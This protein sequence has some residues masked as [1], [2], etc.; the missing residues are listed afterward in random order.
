MT[1][2]LSQWRR[3]PTKKQPPYRP[4]LEA[5]EQRWLPTSVA[6][7]AASYG[8]SEYS[9]SFFV[10]VS[11]D[12]APSGT[13]T[14][15]YATADGTA[16]AGSDYTATSGTLTFTPS[17]T[18]A[19]VAI[20]IT[21][22]SE[23]E[24]NETFTFTLSSPGAGLTLGSP[25]SATITIQDTDPRHP[26][27]AA[28]PLAVA[29]DAGLAT[30]TVN[31][32]GAMAV[33]AT[34]AYATRDG[35]AVSAGDLYYRDYLPVT[36][37]LTFVPGQS[38]AWFT[39]PIVD[40]MI[41]GE[42][43]EY[44]Y[45]D[46]SNPSSG[47]AWP[48]SPTATLTIHDVTATDYL[49]TAPPSAGDPDDRTPVA[50]GPVTVDPQDGDVS[51]GHDLSGDGGGVVSPGGS[52]QDA[53]GCGCPAV[54]WWNQAPGVATPPDPSAERGG[55]LLD[56]AGRIAFR[57]VLR[58][59]SDTAQPRPV[60]TTT[61]AT[62]AA[63]PAPAA[64]SVRLVRGGVAQAW[65]TP[66]PAGLAAGDAF[67]VGQQADAAVAAT[68]YYEYT[69]QVM[70]GYA[71]RGPI[72]REVTVRQGVQVNAGPYGAGWNVDGADQLVPVTGGMLRVYG[73][74]GTRFFARD[75]VTGAFTGP[76]NDAG[77]LTANV[78]GTYGYLSHDGAEYNFDAVGRL[79]TVKD[80]RGL[81]VTF[82]YAGPGL[83][84]VTNPDGG[85][86]TFGYAAGSV[87][88]RRPDGGLATLAF[89]P[90]GTSSYGTKL[91]RIT[92]ADG[93]SRDLGYDDHDK[94]TQEQ[95]GPRT[96]NVTYDASWAGA[97]AQVAAGASW[98]FAP[99]QLRGLA[100]SGGSAD[101][102][103]ATVTDPLGRTATL[104]LDGAGRL[105][106][107][108]TPDGAEQSWSRDAAGRVTARTDALG[109]A[110]SFAYSGAD[111]TARTDALGHAWAYGYGAFGRLESR[112]DP[113]GGRT[114]YA[115]DAITGDLL[116]A[117]DPAGGLTTYAWS[118]GLLQSVTD[119]DGHV[120]TYSYTA[121]RRLESVRQPTGELL[122]YS[123]DAAGLPALLRGASGAATTLLYDALGRVTSSQSA[124]LGATTYAYDAL[125]RLT[126]VTGP[127][128]A[129]TGYAYLGGGGRTA[130]TAYAGTA[131]ARTEGALYDA[132]G[133]VTGALDAF[134]QL[135]QYLV[136]A[137]GRASVTV[138]PLGNRATTLFDPA[139]NATGVYDA[140][141]QLTKYLYDALNRL[142]VTVDPLGQRTTSLFDAA[143]HLTGGYDSHGQL[144]Q[145][146]YDAAGRQT[147][148][149]DVY[150]NRTTTLLDAAGQVTGVRD[151]F[152]QLTQ[153][154]Y[155]AS[156]RQTVAVDVLGRRTT[157][158]LDAAGRVTGVL[159]AHGGLAQYLYDGYG[160]Q[161][162]VVDPLGQRTTS[163]LDALGRATGSL[164]A[165][166]QLTQFLYDGLGR[167]T[168]AAGPLGTRTTTLHDA[169]GQATGAL[170]ERGNLTQYVYDGYGRQTVV[171]DT[172]GRRTTSLL[173]GHG[174]VTGVRDALGNLTQYL[175]D[176]YGRQTVA[177]DALQRRT[178]TLLDGFGQVTGVLD[179]LGNLTQYLYDGYGRQTV[180]VDALQR[181]G[182][183][184]FD[185][186]D[187]VT[188]SLDARG[189]LTQY[190]Y[191][192]Y[193]RQSVVVDP[194]DRRTTTLFGADG[195]VTG[196][197]DPRG[198]LTQY[199]YDGLG[200]QTVV[201]DALQGRTTTLLDGHGQVTGALDA[202]GNLTQYLYDAYGRQTVIVDALS[203][204]ATTLLDALGQATGVL[205][206][207]GRLT[208]Y[209]Y[210][211]YGRQTVVVD[212]EG[213]RATTLFDGLG[214]VTGGL[215]RRGNLTRYVYDG[216]GRQ[217]VVVDA[218]AG[219]ATT[220]YNALGQ[221]TGALDARNKLTQFLY[222]GLGR[223]TVVVDAEGGRST[224]LFDGQGQVTGA[225]DALN[226]LTQFVFDAYGR[227]TVTV[228]GAGGR[229]TSLFDDSGLVTGTLDARN[230]LTRYA[231]D[232]LGRQTAVTQAAGTAAERTVTTLYDAS[233]NVT[234][235]VNGRGYET[236]FVYDA[237]NRQTVVIDPLGHRTTTLLDA[238]GNV[239][240]VK[241]ATNQLT[242]YGYDGLNRRVTV[243]DA[244][245]KT[246]TTYYDAA[247][248]VTGVRD[249]NNLLT[250]YR[251]DAL[252][253][254]T[255]TID[256]R[257]YRTTTLY[258]AAGNVTSVTDAANNT[259][260]FAYDG[261]GRKTAQTDALGHTATFAYDAAGLLASATDPLGQRRAFQYDAANR[262]TAELWYSAGGSAVNT[263]SYS[264]DANGN[265]LTAADADGTYTLTYDALNR[266]STVRDLWGLTQTFT[267]DAADN[268]TGVQD[269][270]GGLQASTYDAANR[271]TWREQSASG[272]TIHLEFTY[273]ARGE[274]E[275]VRR[276]SGTV[277]PFP[278]IALT[279]YNYDG[280]GRVTNLQHTDGS[281]G[282][283]ANY[284]YTYD[285]GGRLTLE[286]RD[287]S[288]TSYTYDDSSQLTG[289]GAGT[290]SYDGA[291]N[292]TMTGYSTG[293]GNRLT[294][295]GTWTYTYDAA[296][297]LTKK[298]KGST[299]ET[300]TYGYD[301][302]GELTW[303]EKRATDGGTLQSRAEY[304]YD[305]FG[306]RV[307]KDVDSDGNGVAD[308]TQK[309][310]LDGWDPAKAGGVG[311]EAFDVWAD[312]DGG[313]SLTTRY[314]R[315]DVV[316]QLFAR[317]GS[318][319]VAYWALA[320]RLGSVG[321]VVDGAGAVKDTIRYD[322]YG[323]VTSESDALY[324]G[325]YKYT[326]REYDAETGLQYN[327]RRYYDAGIGGWITQDP[328]GF[329]AGDSNL[330]RYVNNRPTGATDP[331]GLDEIG[332]NPLYRVPNQPG[333]MM[334]QQ[335][336]PTFYDLKR[337]GPEVIQPY[338]P[339][340]QPPDF[341]PTKQIPVLTGPPINTRPTMW[342]D[343][344]GLEGQDE[345]DEFNNFR[346]NYLYP[347]FEGAW[348]RV[349]GLMRRM[350]PVH[351]VTEDLILAQ[352]IWND[353][354]TL[355]RIGQEK[356]QQIN[357]VQPVTQAIAAWRGIYPRNPYDV[358]FSKRVGRNVGA[359]TVDVALEVAIGFGIQT[360]SRF[361][362]PGTTP[363]ACPSKTQ[364]AKVLQL[365]ENFAEFVDDAFE[366]APMGQRANHPGSGAFPAPATP[367][368][369]PNPLSRANLVNR[370][371]SGT[372]QQ[373]IATAQQLG[374]EARAL[375]LQ[376]REA[377]TAA[378]DFVLAGVGYRPGLRNVLV[379]E[380]NGAVWRTEF[381]PARVR[382][383]PGQHRRLIE[384]NLEGAE[385]LVP[386]GGG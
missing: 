365:P 6:L 178:T 377:Q 79:A 215:D 221:V 26:S 190:A 316:D 272:A 324:G 371:G 82:A 357:D 338:P 24:P 91:I 149:V 270:L 61:V 54:D 222:D 49:P 206:P 142:T 223:Q 113:L 295:D 331:S 171:V 379:I 231:Y 50:V 39:V 233:G 224:T 134:G 353:K 22:D 60:L 133:R 37:T 315:G 277:S 9:P 248:G 195:A 48:L 161:T 80:A 66:A 359:V 170:D 288:T 319:G 320:D 273:T 199:V 211:G 266:V 163:L 306:S 184:L 115:Y 68:G 341:R 298:S 349:Y 290:Y 168:A 312:L 207:L 191:D 13:V 151:P 318:S 64:L 169:L 86:Y 333:T 254:T 241:D 35:T 323:N 225:L 364:S 317:I 10:T 29:E 276:Y 279:S 297:N 228:D 117:R 27:F 186:H 125:G 200:R 93:G 104:A 380:T 369:P 136:D 166:G 98:S 284:T 289:D 41:A 226:H 376:V 251:L 238:A 291:G 196:V 97:S 332:Q 1:W 321:D 53:N 267:Y 144:T 218:L 181:R 96:T 220:M 109:H 187:L 128:G 172:L 85:V 259:T 100:H 143:G 252:G 180:V 263:L 42:G 174:Q 160:R 189:G 105:L 192:A 350:D 344:S 140:Y 232:L 253:R 67:V 249:A 219:R 339:M 90:V 162:V 261:L 73:A 83:G 340:M 145:Y 70:I 212:G 243:T 141:G 153:Y 18:S 55:L 285:D 210:D 296:G 385:Q 202:R 157:S 260:T 265:K 158:L 348:G 234:A 361:P 367:T 381:N 322:G 16:A 12:A 43:D 328:L 156:G 58:Y 36:G 126:G 7:G 114:T 38:S 240:G 313:G 57:P 101:N 213:G 275:T 71:G 23:H 216:F 121:A 8:T 378:G 159:D 197:L 179:A 95:K 310:A 355:L 129:R 354:S 326:G 63:D 300:W 345:R 74:G 368:P 230:T 56:A 363:V 139:G 65:S 235:T 337:Q 383:T 372:V 335:G 237:L 123:Y 3:P 19:N 205:D 262:L 193:G 217:T 201:V 135:T 146:L 308:T 327:R 103:V 14:V 194:L 304:K 20:P 366:N 258:D 34:L 84:S 46:L 183:T 132:A 94:L 347:R 362:G 343:P 59:H 351:A 334:P 307:E 44:L 107:L 346:E 30:V 209:L 137:A 106:Q 236:D 25:A 5:L 89:N 45:L 118:N 32:D 31:L 102:D 255:V 286:V 152:G 309:Y 11:L 370:L 147:V 116:T 175:Y 69:L 293:T 314:L 356:L 108:R 214:Q 99:R 264:Y 311:N 325:R 165:Y 188:G 257:N 271:L 386:P 250:Q 360:G 305:A 122:T 88:V 15:Q 173:D 239:T 177:V 352:Q 329:G 185:A 17:L 342:T 358:A 92:D 281:G 208:Q 182:T 244:L 62:D 120:T 302:R 148:V 167:L 278:L 247:G 246:A 269:S 374:A 274:P 287:G 130:A 198:G 227:Q 150:G 110:T 242:Q 301:N 176:A 87:S 245:N 229:V 47:L 138:D 76:A 283:V 52:G 299:A 256:P 336:T 382:W 2:N 127:D 155:D 330:Y 28:G 111:L 81:A 124:G 131:S 21:D 77:L 373:R 40:D 78:D 204:R 294:T 203:G 303:A 282:N 119:P 112:A 375:G 51:L 33:T 292:R 154:A 280:T 75:P 4:G 268:R 164:D 384:V 72:H